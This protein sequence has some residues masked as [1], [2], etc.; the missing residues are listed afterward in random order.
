M[1]PA[2]LKVPVFMTTEQ[3]RAAHPIYD[4][5][6]N[7]DGSVMTA[8]Q[9]DARD[10][11]RLDAAKKS[12]QLKRALLWGAAILGGGGLLLYALTRK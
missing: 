3:W 9:A 11:L 12:A 10:G 2:T 6:R 8:A 7:P 1:P 5:E 4:V